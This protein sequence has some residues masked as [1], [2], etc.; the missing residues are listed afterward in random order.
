MKCNAHVALSAMFV[1]FFH[2]PTEE[3]GTKHTHG[4]RRC[5]LDGVAQRMMDHD[6]LAMVSMERT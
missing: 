5:P 6:A 2:R 4:E 3:V 1:E